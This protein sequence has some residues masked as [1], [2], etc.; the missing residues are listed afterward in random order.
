[1]ATD[2]LAGKA[3]SRNLSSSGS[4]QIGSA[5]ENRLNHL[6]VKLDDSKDRSEHKEGT[7]FHHL[8]QDATVF[9]QEWAVISQGETVVPAALSETQT[10]DP[11]RRHPK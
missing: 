4:P 1:M 8:V 10:A 2:N 6:R 5:N 11:L 3:A 7:L 9:I